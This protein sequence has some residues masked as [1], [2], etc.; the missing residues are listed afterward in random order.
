MAGP[1]EQTDASDMHDRELAGLQRGAQ[2]PRL[3]DDLVRSRDAMTWEATAER[4]YRALQPDS[5]P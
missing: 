2:A 4:L 3:V 5:S 1:H